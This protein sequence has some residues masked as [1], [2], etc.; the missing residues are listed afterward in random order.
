M[1]T[2]TWSAVLAAAATPSAVSTMVLGFGTVFIGLFALILIIQLMG[3]IMKKFGKKAEEK[4]AAPVQAPAPVV[5][6][7]ESAPE[8][9]A[10]EMV[11]EQMDPADR[12]QMIA[13]IAACV[14]TV[15][16][17]DISGIRILSVTKVN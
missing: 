12:Q 3:L 16:G 17:D 1:I 11:E 8:Q 13:A 14:A 4:P 7:P 15:M 6:A 2:N 10:S 9:E 5:S